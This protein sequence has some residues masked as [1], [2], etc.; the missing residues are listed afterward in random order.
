MPVP[1]HPADALKSRFAGYYPRHGA[2]WLGVS[3]DGMEYDDWPVA[4]LI[5]REIFRPLLLTRYR[6]KVARPEKVTVL[7]AGD[8]W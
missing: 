2:V 8:A 7:W 3:L 5:E 1:T 4:R 6:R